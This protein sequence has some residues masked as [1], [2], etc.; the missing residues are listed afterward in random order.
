[1]VLSELARWLVPDELWEIVEP[2]DPRVI[3]EAARWWDGVAGRAAGA[4]RDR[5]H[6]DQRL[7]LAAVTRR[8]RHHP[9]DGASPV[10]RL[11]QDGL[12][13]RLHRAVLDELGGCGTVDRISAIVD[14]AAV[15][16][17]MGAR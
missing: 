15:S 17:K 2:L 9:I 7:H 13:S 11:D 10:R 5:V 6:A 16:A 12:W 4:H 3:A 8:V 1:M 14:A